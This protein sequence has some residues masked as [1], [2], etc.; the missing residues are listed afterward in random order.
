[1]FVLQV[2]C[3]VRSL[4]SWGIMIISHLAEVVVKGSGG[5]KKNKKKAASSLSPERV[6]LEAVMQSFLSVLSAYYLH[7][8]RYV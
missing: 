6:Q 3:V 5:K 8:C 4:G 1:M 2:T 7:F